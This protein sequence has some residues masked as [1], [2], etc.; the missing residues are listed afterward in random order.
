MVEQVQS[1]DLSLCVLVDGWYPHRIVCQ[2]VHGRAVPVG[3]HR[4]DAGGDA[5]SASRSVRWLPRVESVVARVTTGSETTL[6]IARRRRRCDGFW[7][8]LEEELQ[9]T[10]VQRRWFHKIGNV[11]NALPKSQRAPSRYC[12]RRPVPRHG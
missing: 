2:E 8:T 11:L 3:D 1:V 4:C 5:R 7:V 6:V 12:R 9:R 10:R